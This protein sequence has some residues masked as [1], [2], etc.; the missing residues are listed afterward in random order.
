MTCLLLDDVPSHCHS[1]GNA[2]CLRQQVLNLA[3]G[4]EE[5][6]LCLA[7]LAVDNGQSKEELLLSLAAYIVN[8][9][10]FL[11]SW[12]RYESRDFCPDPQGCLPDLCFIV[13]LGSAS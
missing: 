2:L 7:C 1:C 5:Q 4:E 8:R 9:E 3:L 6:V 12:D 13:R 11:K 10:C